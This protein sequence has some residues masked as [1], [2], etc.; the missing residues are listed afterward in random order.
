D[1]FDRLVYCSYVSWADFDLW[2]AWFRVW[3]LGN[4]LGALGPITLYLRYQQDRNPALL[5]EV[6]KPPYRGL[7]GIDLEEYAQLFEQAGAHVDAFREGRA[8]AKQAS[9]QIFRLLADFP[10]SP[11]QVHIAD[12]AYRSLNDW[13]L[14]KMI[15]IWTWGR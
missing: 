9:E 14:P 15:R 13:T 10:L 7:A 8:S 1:H 12:P 5:A 4:I 2:N 3:A 11:K 6:E